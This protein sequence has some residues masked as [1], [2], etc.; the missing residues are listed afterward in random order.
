MSVGLPS[1]D[2][3]TR[4]VLA[5]Q[6]HVLNSTRTPHVGAVPVMTLLK[7]ALLGTYDNPT[8]EVIL[9][10]IETL[11]TLSRVTAITPDFLRPTYTAF[12]D[13]SPRLDELAESQQAE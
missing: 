3:L 6:T 4:A 13:V 5:R 1:T 10:A 9:H 2:D 7:R 11:G 8:F 12:T